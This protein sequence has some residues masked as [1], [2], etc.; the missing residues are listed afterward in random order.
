[1]T[2]SNDD[3]K[4]TDLVAGYILNDLSP[5][6]VDHL[7][8]ALVENQALAEELDAFQEAIALLPYDMPLLEPSTR[9]RDK[10]ISAASQSITSEPINTNVVPVASL[11]QRNRKQWIPAI[12]IGITAVAVTALG[13]SQV[14][15]SRQAQQTATLQQKLD[16]TNTEL[17]R[18]QHELDA[19]QS[20]IARLSQPDTKVYSLVGAPSAPN[21]ATAR[22]LA[23]PGDRTVTLVAQDL[24]KLSQNQIYRLWAVST[25]SVAPAYCGQFRQD[26]TGKAQWVAPNAACTKN[27]S[28]LLIT[29]DA[30]SDPITSAGPLVMQSTS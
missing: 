27:P 26:N 12:S 2:R 8:Q 1:M 21:R 17:K 20:T 25:P 10:I 3:T 9:L 11:H 24:P 5:E 4:E 15:L 22:L 28:Q 16:A 6:E 19:N 23:K 18:L 30:P 7:N 29:L 13:L 14:Q